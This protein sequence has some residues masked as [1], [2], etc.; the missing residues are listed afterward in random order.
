[1]SNGFVV[2]E[3][4]SRLDGSPIVLIVTGLKRKS[5]N[6]KTGAMVQSY[7]L[8]RDVAPLAS[9][10]TPKAAIHDHFKTGHLKSS[11]TVI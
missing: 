7:I 4:A 11:G 6:R 8:R 3:G 1:M 5:S 2:W 9:V 10:I